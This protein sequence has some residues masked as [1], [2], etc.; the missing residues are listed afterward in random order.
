MTW[1]DTTRQDMTWHDTTR[2][3]KTWHDMTWHYTKLTTLHVRTRATRQPATCVTTSPSIA[4]GKR[5]KECKKRKFRLYNSIVKAKICTG[6]LAHYIKIKKDK[7][8]SFAF[9][10][11]LICVSILALWQRTRSKVNKKLL[12]L[13]PSIWILSWKN[14]QTKIVPFIKFCLQ[15]YTEC[16][17]IYLHY[18][19]G[20]FIYS[21]TWKNEKRTK[22]AHEHAPTDT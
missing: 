20:L 8:V 12:K 4:N 11:L 3:D 17:P 5:M 13:L 6:A 2:H 16:T 7:I 1:H 14:R 19:I 18:F 21:A 10:C 22:L 15:I 9:N